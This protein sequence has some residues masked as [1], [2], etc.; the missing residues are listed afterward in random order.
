MEHGDWTP[1]DAPGNP[2][3]LPAPE[4]ASSASDQGRSAPSP[5]AA[6]TRP[7]WVLL[8]AVLAGV[9]IGAVAVTI[10]GALRAGSTHAGAPGR[11]AAGGAGLSHGRMVLPGASVALPAHWAVLR[12]PA[13]AHSVG[14]APK[15]APPCPDTVFGGQPACQDGLALAA[16]PG[17]GPR[18][19]LDRQARIR[20]LAMHGYIRATALLYEHA[21]TFGGC[22]AY[23][24]EWHVTWAKPPTTV[25]ELII[26]RT[27]V[28]YAG[29]RLE[30]VFIRF[31]DTAA[32]PPQPLI[33]AVAAT[34]RCTA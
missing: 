27:G 8:S 11:P 19:A 1:P 18:Q 33:N 28:S 29:S 25:E 22:P 16:V 26:V 13:S 12:I 3:G 14:A 15:L 9:L 10:T 17:T 30:S 5:G 23:V 32:A 6:G 2:V 7:P 4:H 31:A 20:F 34:V 24:A 21:T